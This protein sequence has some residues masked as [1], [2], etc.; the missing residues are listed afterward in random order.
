MVIAV[1][2]S[3]IH[4]NLNTLPIASK[5]LR[6]ALTK[7]EDLKV[8]LI[9]AGDLHDTKAI[10]R[11]EVMNE[12]IYILASART[13]VY[14]LVGN[15]DLCNERGPV[16]GLEYLDPYATIVDSPR[17]LSMGGLPDFFL[18][19]HLIPYYSDLNKL[20]QY[21]ATLTPGPLMI[22]H[23]GFRGAY[24]GDYI[25]DKTSISVDAV[26][27][28][29]VISG[30]YHRHQ[31]LG[32]VT[33]IGSPYTITFGEAN[34]GP[35]GFLILNSDGTFTREILNLR[36]H[37]VINCGIKDVYES[38]LYKDYNRERGDLLW[39]KVT[40]ALSELQKLDKSAFPNIKLE[41]IPTDSQE[42]KAPTKEMTGEEIFDSIIDNLSDSVEHRSNLKRLYR[43]ITQG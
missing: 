33:Y 41:L 5:A 10:I 40:G 2:T 4:F 43:E 28:F 35:K 12:L 24:M 13:P 31:T 32:T 36:K 15:H 38:E 9:I 22:M 14:I 37:L 8:P 17:I 21:I 34:D 6:A 19:I 23:Q 27:D 26:K 16:H 30:H 7:A 42:L 20:K 29:T 39:L 18:C 1:I 11:A 25:Q 3:D